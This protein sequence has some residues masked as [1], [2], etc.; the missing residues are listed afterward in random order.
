M[1]EGKIPIFYH[2][3]YLTLHCNA[4]QG[5]KIHDENWP[6]HRDVKTVEH[7]AEQADQG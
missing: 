7:S 1:G 5:N 2:M 6:E 4:E 3:L